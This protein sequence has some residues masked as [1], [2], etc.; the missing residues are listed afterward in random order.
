MGSKQVSLLS[1]TAGVNPLCD[2]GR[3]DRE[4]KRKAAVTLPAV[5]DVQNK[6]M[7]FEIYKINIVVILKST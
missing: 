7:G 3:F 2:F 1:T 6:N 5:F 4:Q